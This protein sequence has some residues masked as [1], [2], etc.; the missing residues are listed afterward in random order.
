M[1]N[2]L[3]LASLSQ[4]FQFWHNKSLG[5]HPIHSII[6]FKE[7][8]IMVLNEYKSTFNDLGC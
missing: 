7:K 3:L 1:R 8:V 5:K 6:N 2:V 4:T